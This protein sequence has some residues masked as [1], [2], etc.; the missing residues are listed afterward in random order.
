MSPLRRITLSVC[1]LSLLCVVAPRLRAQEP[2]AD[3]AGCKDSSLLS[4]IPGCWIEACAVKDFDSV[5]VYPEGEKPDVFE[6]TKQKSVEGKVAI[7]EYSCPANVSP[8]Q[9]ARNAESALRTAGYSVVMSGKI[10]NDVGSHVPAVVGKKGGQWVQVVTDTGGRAYVMSAV[11]E[12]DMNQDMK[13]DA[14][15]MAAEIR[16]TGHVAVYGV[17]FD[18]GQ[19]TIKA[20]SNAVLGEMVTLLKANADW[21]M[22]IEGHTDNVGTKEL[23]DSLSTRRAA[24]VEAWLVTH[25][26]DGA[27]LTHAGYGS[28]HPVGDN[29]TEEGRARNRRVELV[30]M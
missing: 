2:Q 28:G 11:Q 23:N 29:T 20:E 8:L 21:K 18:S 3:A 10:T 16:R 12:A 14:T 22:R 5:G 1:A 17:T 15:A 24:A 13:A 9:I 27:R 4:R 7:V 25:G 6:V 26:V 30:K 19:S